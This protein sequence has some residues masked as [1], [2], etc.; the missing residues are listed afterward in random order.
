M[1]GRPMSQER[2]DEFHDAHRAA[3]RGE[4]YD[5]RGIGD[6][7]AGIPD[8]VEC[9]ECENKVVDLDILWDENNENIIGCKKC[10]NED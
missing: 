5:Y 4:D 6:P 3:K 10:I 9:P 1:Y 8:A 7:G 2:R